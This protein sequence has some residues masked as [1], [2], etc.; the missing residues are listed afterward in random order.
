MS[1][2]LAIENGDLAARGDGLGIVFGVDKL[3]QDLTVWLTE[4]F[5]SDIMHPEM[6]S[7][8][9]SW[10]GSVI[11]SSTKAD[12][13]SEV[14][15]VLQNYQN[16]QVRGIKTTPQRY[17]LSEILYSIDDIQVLVGY[18]TVS[19]V[20]SVSTAPPQSQIANIIVTAAANS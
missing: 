13:Q 17:S 14:L 7:M 1:F 12:V 4:K 15:R 6:G 8:L 5:G 18:D 2:S 16:V 11:S 9:D 19:V 10:I 3:V 20:I